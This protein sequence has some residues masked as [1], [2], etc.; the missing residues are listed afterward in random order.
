MITV[1]N[2][3]TGDS[4]AGVCVDTNAAIDGG[5]VEVGS[6]GPGTYAVIDGSDDNPAGTP[7]VGYAGISTYNTGAQDTCD[8]NITNAPGPIEDT[9]DE[10]SGTNGGGCFTIR[11]VASIPA[12]PFACGNASGPDFTA[13]GRDGCTIP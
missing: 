4:I 11:G 12:L 6:G 13:A 5:Y 3:V 2:G 9:T 10:G 1:G 7:A 8:P